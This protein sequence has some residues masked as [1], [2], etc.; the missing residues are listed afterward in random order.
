M[1]WRLGICW[2]G[3]LQELGEGLRGWEV[4][5]DGER[6]GHVKLAQCHRL[7]LPTPRG[8]GRDPPSPESK[9]ASQVSKAENDMI[10]YT[11]G[12][13]HFGCPM[14]AGI[15]LDLG[16]PVKEVMTIIKLKS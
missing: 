6:G 16:L 1:V 2:V 15:R 4:E 11:T 13:D 14:G 8:L 3:P 10:K 5:S 9:E 7:G 12:Q